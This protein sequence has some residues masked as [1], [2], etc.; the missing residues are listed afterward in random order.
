MGLIPGSGRSHEEGNGHLFQYSCLENLMDREAWRAT[1]HGVTKSWTRLATDAPS[2]LRY[3]AAGIQEWKGW[4]SA[5][6]WGGKREDRCTRDLP[7]VVKIQHGYKLL[8]ETVVIQVNIS[9]VCSEARSL[10]KN[11]QE[12]KTLAPGVLLQLSIRVCWQKPCSPQLRNPFPIASRLFTDLE[13]Y[14][15]CPQPPG[16]NAQWSEVELM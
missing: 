4:V 11:N 2:L 10:V 5:P 12:Q 15:R 8:L 3:Q 16:S 13:S 7:V 1:V 9:Q 14:S 6:V